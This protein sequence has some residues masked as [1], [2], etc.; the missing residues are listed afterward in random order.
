[1]KHSTLLLLST[2][3]LLAGCG[4]PPSSFSSSET[5]PLPSESEIASS[6]V[7]SPV[8][9]TS[10]PYSQVSEVP[11]VSDP[12][13]EESTIPSIEDTSFVSETIESE[14]S[15]ESS[16]EVHFVVSKK[17][18]G[19]SLQYADSSFDPN[20]VLPEQTVSFRLTALEE[21]YEL[22]GVYYTIESGARFT[23]QE[24]DGLYSFVMPYMNVTISVESVRNYALNVEA[25][26]ATVTFENEVQ[27]YYR[28][29]TRIRFQVAADEGYSLRKVEYTYS[30]SSFALTEGEDGYYFFSMPSE[31]ATLVVTVSQIIDSS[32][33]PWS[34]KDVTYGAE[35]IDSSYSN[36][37]AW[38]FH[39]RG[40][41][42]FDFR[43]DVYYYDDGYYDE[44][45]YEPSLGGPNIVY[46]EW[47]FSNNRADDKNVTY[48]YSPD[49]GYYAA[50]ISTGYAGGTATAYFSVSS[51]LSEKGVPST[52]TLVNS[53]STHEFFPTAGTVFTL[54]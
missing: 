28:S 3:L 25:E 36:K 15:I 47:I 26:H 43:C 20:Y 16:E 22:S 9:E 6:E 31:T 42:T 4:T 19:F 52:I 29:G 48:T 17:T 18:S 2:S 37:Y 21:Y 38:S 12:L 49:S 7:S 11:S 40:D 44:W 53:Y 24:T 51:T 39:F 10:L 46:Y 5:S 14:E 35:K 30:S 50:T 34:G 23:I 13:S 32:S 33:D 54:R 27:A 8:E 45:A 41:G 1:M